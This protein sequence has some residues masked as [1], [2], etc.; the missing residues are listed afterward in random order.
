MAPAVH[1]PSLDAQSL[2][3][4][5]LD[6]QAV[7]VPAE[8]AGYIVPGLHHKRRKC[9]IADRQAHTMFGQM[10]TQ[11]R[12]GLQ[13]R[14][15]TH[16]SRVPRHDVLDRARKDVAVVR[17]ARCKRRPVVEGKSWLALRQLHPKRRNV[18]RGRMGTDDAEANRRRC[19]QIAG[20]GLLYTLT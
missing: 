17:K 16:L 8:A 14:S 13:S 4:L 5:E 15:S 11:L 19:R 12:S 2:V 18:T 20:A 10:Q 9:E 1:S 7:A 3:D 6:G